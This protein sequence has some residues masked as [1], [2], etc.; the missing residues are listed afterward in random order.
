M[1]I[2][3]FEEFP[4]AK[5]LSKLSLINWPIK[6]YVGANSV[7]EFNQIRFTLKN[8]Y[9]KEVIYW[10]LLKKKEGYWISPFSSRSALQRTFRELNE[11]KVFVMLDLELPT[12][13]NPW[14]YLTEGLNFFRN[15]NLIKNFI[16]NYAGQVYLAEYYPRG[17]LMGEILEFFGLHYR[18]KKLNIIKMIYHSMHKFNEEFI[19]DEMKHGR[20]E[21]G[22]RF[23]AAYG[24]IARGIQRNEPILSLKQLKKDLELADSAGIKEVIIY[25][26]GGLNRSYANLLKQFKQSKK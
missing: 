14:L 20:K 2:S 15:R 10:P 22:E 19:F 5:N 4:T 8:K 16:E 7:A 3:F 26:L 24:T 25:R 23:L 18:N 13:R 11:K 12:T 1:Q 21:R 9:V 6:L 17:K